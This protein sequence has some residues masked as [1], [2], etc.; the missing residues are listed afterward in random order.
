[1][2][3]EEPEERVCDASWCGK[4]LVQREGESLQNFTNRRHCDR[5]CAASHVSDRRPKSKQRRRRGCAV[6]GLMGS[7]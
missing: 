4:P 2:E 5:R 3:G 6:I 7:R 1:M